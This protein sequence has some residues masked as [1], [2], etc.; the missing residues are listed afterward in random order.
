MEGW[1]GRGIFKLLCTT[2]RFRNFFNESW[3]FNGALKILPL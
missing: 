2:I 1:E 3:K